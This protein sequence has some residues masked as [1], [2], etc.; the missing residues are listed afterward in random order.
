M[1]KKIKKFLAEMNIDPT[2]R[3]EG[4]GATVAAVGQGSIH[5]QNDG[6][7]YAVLDWLGSYSDPANYK[8]FSINDANAPTE[9]IAY[10]GI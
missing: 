10:L 1:R 7:I 3:I 9:I 6:T 5:F 4:D 8:K 2:L